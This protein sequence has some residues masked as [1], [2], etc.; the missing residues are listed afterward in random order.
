[1]RLI[2]AALGLF[3]GYRLLA[4]GKEEDATAEEI[5]SGGKVDSSN[6]PM[7]INSTPNG[8]ATPVRRYTGNRPQ[9]M[10]DKYFNKAMSNKNLVSTIP[11]KRQQSPG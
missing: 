7:D 10:A 3:L 4:K 5:N 8:L 2:L 9:T 6:R 1:M 11:V